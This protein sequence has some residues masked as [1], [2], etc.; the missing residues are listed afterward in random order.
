[1]GSPSNS[2]SNAVKIIFGHMIGLHPEILL[3]LKKTVF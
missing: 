1:M 3:K 2:K